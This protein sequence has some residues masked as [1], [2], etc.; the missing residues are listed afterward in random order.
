[1]PGDRIFV[2]IQAVVVD[3]VDPIAGNDLLDGRMGCRLRAALCDLRVNVTSGSAGQL[4]QHLFVRRDGRQVIVWD[5]TG[6]PLVNLTFPEPGR[7]A[8]AIG[9]DGERQTIDGFDGH[10]IKGVRLG[11]GIARIFEIL[12]Q[13][14]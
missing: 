2:E 12:P 6:E 10:S 14:D 11:A 4:Y 9:L 13:A 8:A 7:T 5:K 3:H 1:M